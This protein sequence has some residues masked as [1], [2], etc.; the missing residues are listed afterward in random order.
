MLI[1]KYGR[2]LSVTSEDKNETH[3]RLDNLKQTTTKN[4]GGHFDG[5]WELGKQNGNTLSL[6]IYCQKIP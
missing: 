1:S 5:D 4:G 3:L 6:N 2:K